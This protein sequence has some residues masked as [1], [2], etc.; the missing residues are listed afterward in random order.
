MAVSAADRAAAGTAAY[1]SVRGAGL[2]ASRVASRASINAG[3]LTATGLTGRA[4]T[5]DAGRAAG[6]VAIRN[7]VSAT[8]RVVAGAA[9]SAAVR[10]FGCSHVKR[11]NGCIRLLP[12]ATDL[13]PI[14][15]VRSRAPRRGVEGAECCPMAQRFCEIL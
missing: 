14:H 13:R 15:T 1:A 8:A 10:E 4:V 12:F 3:V 7:A 11:I 2:T 6:R 5:Y 9:C